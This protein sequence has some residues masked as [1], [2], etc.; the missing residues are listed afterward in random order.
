MAIRR[1]RAVAGVSQQRVAEAVGVQQSS[2]S[3]WERGVTNPSG[4]H[5]D[6]LRRALPDLAALLDEQEPQ[7]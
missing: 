2:V 3:Q 4:W 7:R 1:A 5:M 6:C